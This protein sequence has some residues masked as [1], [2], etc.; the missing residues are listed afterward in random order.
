MDDKEKQEVIALLE[1]DLKCAEK[2]VSYHQ[3]LVDGLEHAIRYIKNPPESE[4]A[5]TEMIKGIWGDIR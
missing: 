2:N 1:L 4:K 3:G 5:I